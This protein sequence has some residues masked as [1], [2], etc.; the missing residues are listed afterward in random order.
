MPDD[1]QGF[2]FPRRGILLILSAPSGA[3]KTTLAR[4]LIS[5]SDNL[6]WSIS[7]TTRVCRAGEVEGQDYHFV[8]ED[9]FLTLR[10]NNAFAEWAK[11]HGAYY[12]TA[13]ATI[14]AA[15]TSGQDLLLDIDVQGAA[16]LKAAYPEAV[17][18]FI[19]PPSCSE[20]E[21]R[22]RGRGTD[23][24]EEITQRIRRAR[25]EVRELSHYDYCVIND[26]IESGV[27]SL[28][29]ILS[30]ERV[31]LSRLDVSQAQ[32]SGSP[33]HGAVKTGTCS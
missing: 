10:K 8:S 30:A 25:E 5:K 22:L 1:E 24:E 6:R 33:Q 18:A 12:G 9:T 3:G 31:R 17:S 16:Q 11:V 21:S 28:H 32:C 27:A 23:H 4:Q 19:L 15:L 2:T 29:A 7:H 14:D 13:R 26:E 20:L